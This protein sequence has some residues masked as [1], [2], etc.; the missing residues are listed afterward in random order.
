M[1]DDAQT[2]ET[3]SEAADHSYAAVLRSRAWVECER[4]VF[5]QRQARRTGAG[6]TYP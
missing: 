1:L 6:R 3:L 4:T 5:L 2:G